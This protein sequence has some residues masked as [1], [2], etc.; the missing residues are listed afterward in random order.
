LR[1]ASK[2][3]RAAGLYR[4]GRRAEAEPLFAEILAADPGSADALFYLGSIAADAGRLGR[5]LGLLERA[6]ARKPLEGAFHAA[7]GNVQARAAD[8]ERALASYRTALRLQPELGELEL[9]V[10]HALRAL[11][12]HEEAIAAYRACSTGSRRTRPRASGAR[13]RSLD[14]SGAPKPSKSSSGCAPWAR[15]PPSL[16]RGRPRCGWRSATRTRRHVCTRRSPR[17]R[18]RIRACN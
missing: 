14:C 6:V 15:R 13:W 16:R 4:A 10:G 2:L 3:A 7:L 5:A 1:G 18:A 17:N 11:G 12:R 9:N 8:G